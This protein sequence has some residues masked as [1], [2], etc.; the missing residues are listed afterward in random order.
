MLGVALLGPLALLL[1]LEGQYPLLLL[2][3]NQVMLYWVLSS[4]VDVL[5]FTHSPVPGRRD[6]RPATRLFLA[7]GLA[8][9]AAWLEPRY[10][11]FSYAFLATAGLGLLLLRGREWLWNALPPLLARHL[12]AHGYLAVVLLSGY[13]LLRAW[14][15]VPITSFQLRRYEL[16]LYLIVGLATV[17]LLALWLES[18]LSSRR[19]E[20]ELAHLLGDA[21]RAVLY[22]AV[23]LSLVSTVTQRDVTQVALSSAFFS[24]GL[25]FALKPTLGNLVSGLILRVSHDFA[26]GDFVQIG[27]TYGLV[28]H[29]DWRSVGVGTLEFDTIRIPHSVVAKSVLTNL[30]RPTPQHAGYLDLQL[31]RSLPPGQVRQELLRLL[32]DIPEVCAEPE[33]EVYLLKMDGWANTYRIR[34]WME[35]VGRAPI[36]DSQLRGQLLYGLERKNMAPVSPMRSWLVE[37][38]EELDGG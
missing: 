30:S 21:V 37:D 24:L 23:A 5:W 8:A 26:L 12:R 29:I 32:A 25:G 19:G 2:V 35:H 13:F 28:T 15:V 10:R 18:I 7:A 11:D 17:E 27:K 38:G 33:P 6:W 14:T 1:W 36:Y 20:R 16:V 34:W 9:A 4:V 31:Q 22:S 3:S